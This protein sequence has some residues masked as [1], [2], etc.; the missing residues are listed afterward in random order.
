[1]PVRVR[2]GS[3]ACGCASPPATITLNYQLDGTGTPLVLTHGLGDSLH[4]WDGVAPALAAQH[5]LL[6]WDVRGF[7]ESDK[8]PGPY[9]AELFAADLAAL[10]DALE[11]RPRPPRRHLDGRRDRPALRARPRRPPALADPLQHLERDR[12]R[13]HRQLAPPR[14]Y[15]RAT[16]I[17]RRGARRLALLRA[18]VRRRTSR[19]RRRGRPADRAATTRAPMPPRRGR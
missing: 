1:M 16:R 18:V 13:R 8:P 3:A 17:R 12:R 6:R 15:H 14:R 7:G 10:L 19:R 2:C 5:E 9:S 11:H 4:F